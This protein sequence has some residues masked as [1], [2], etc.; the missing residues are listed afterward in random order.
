MI[1]KV[2]SIARSDKK[3]R[4]KALEQ[5]NQQGLIDADEILGGRKDN[6]THE[7][8]HFIREQTSNRINDNFQNSNEIL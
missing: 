5:L 1:K 8:A 6:D 7:D 2:F 4:K 3:S